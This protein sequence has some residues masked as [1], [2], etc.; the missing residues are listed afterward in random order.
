MSPIDRPSSLCRKVCSPGST[1]PERVPITR[2]CSGV[3]PIEVSTATA[4]AD[5]RGRAAVA[6]VQHDLVELGR[7]P[8][9]QLGAAPGRRTGARCRG[10]RTGGSGAA[11]PARAGSRRCGPPRAGWR[12]RR[13]RR[14]RRAGR[15]KPRPGRLDPGHGARVVQRRQRDQVAD[16][17]DHGV[18]DDHRVGEVRAR[19]APPGA[20]PRRC[21]T[22]S[23]STPALGPARADHRQRDGRAVVGDSA[24]AGLADPLDGALGRDRAGLGDRPAGTS[25]T[26][27]R[28]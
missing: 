15:R 13:C 3:S 12:R 28:R 2:P 1:S 14:P 20:R 22:A 16:L 25:A 5:R 8:A 6:Q 10:S 9:E 26:T 11:R 23:R 21:P 24:A 17:V 27:S 19:R 18:V 4:A 7:V